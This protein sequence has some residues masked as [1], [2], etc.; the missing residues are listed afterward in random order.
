MIALLANNPALPLIPS[1]NSMLP[2]PAQEPRLTPS[3]GADALE[4]PLY[5]LLPVNRAFSNCLHKAWTIKERG[6]G[7]SGPGEGSS[8]HT[9]TL[10]PLLRELARK[11][12]QYDEFAQQDAHELLRHLLDSMEM[13][14]K[15]VIKRKAA[16]AKLL[17]ENAE[18][19]QQ[20]LADAPI[21]SGSTDQEPQEQPAASLSPANVP[22]AL[23]TTV[24]PQSPVLSATP[25]TPVVEDRLVPF[26]DVLFGGLLASVVVCET[27]KSVS[28][29]Y[30]GF[31]DVSL[32]MRGD[33]DQPRL[34]KR[35]RFRAMASRLKPG[36]KVGGQK[37]P[38]LPATMSEP[39]GSD[40]ERGGAAEPKADRR[41]RHA[42]Y[43]KNLS[44]ESDADSDGVRTPS[45]AP[46]GIKASFSFKRKG[47]RTPSASRA[48]TPAT[49][50]PSQ[51]PATLPSA[52]TTGASTP[53]GGSG[54][55]L[56][57]FAPSVLTE[58]LHQH[59]HQAKPTPAQTAY[60]QRILYGPP[61]APE[62]A[63][64]LAKL[65]AAHVGGL[66]AANAA[67]PSDY[68]LVDSLKSFTAVEVLEGDNAFACHKC[69]KIKNGHYRN[70]RREPVS[71]V[72][73]SLAESAPP[74]MVSVVHQDSTLLEPLMG[75]GVPLESTPLEP[76]LSP[77]MPILPAIAVESPGMTV[78][79]AEIF[80]PVPL[81]VG[82]TPGTGSDGSRLGR[83]VSR[84][85]SMVRAASPLRTSKTAADEDNS[86]PD[87]LANPHSNP[88]EIL[89]SDRQLDRFD[90]VTSTGSTTSLST[91]S[92]E[93]NT[94]S[95]VAATSTTMVST[96][97]TT[98]TY[99]AGQSPN[100]STSSLG[101]GQSKDDDDTDG[102][103]DSTDDEEMPGP[104]TSAH[105]G[106]LFRGGLG[107][108][109]SVK[110]QQ[111][112]H[113]VLRRAFKR[114]L[115]AQAPEVLV[116]HIKRFKQT[117]AG[118]YSSFSNLKK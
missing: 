36:V 75:A 117:N 95:S 70:K 92:N 56:S 110:R 106:G 61:A 60:I 38:E 68:G 33:D 105:I 27:C 107:G 6:G 100:A 2:P 103:S 89:G 9:M 32:S 22:A 77:P 12:D 37:F 31:L 7:T 74:S 62:T 46:R 20:Q 55:S 3:L 53:M 48:R 34:R 28:H 30:E 18:L 8:L 43:P 40:T 82:P 79:E 102:L 29:T 11:Y 24:A 73:H 113:F 69:W 4:P 49:T 67:K 109:P 115:I 58:Q 85:R 84:S 114:Y 96:I 14:E 112:K 83:L 10:A 42:H 21:R 57:S 118:L 5:K 44:R 41:G 101:R 80:A 98:S 108:R 66:T 81:S 45:T 54:A 1:P 72:H 87:A 65:R 99:T 51:T 111:S 91:M 78:R 64:P 90:S 116:F 13:E 19:Q 93:Y 97:G 88:M 47:L 26:V 94:S 35:D 76:L 23:P 16:D 52:P 15:D 25:A 104:G 59:V 71:E 63:D 86:S 39:E 17:A 50:S